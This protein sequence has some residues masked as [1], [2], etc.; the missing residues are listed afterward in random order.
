MALDY[1][2]NHTFR[3]PALKPL[4]R[5]LIKISALKSLETH[6]VGLYECGFFRKGTQ[7][8]MEDSMNT[9]LVE[10]RPHMVPLVEAFSIDS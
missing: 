7:Q 9:L 3:D 8:V 5:L 4:L 1:I 10:L 2:D 6:T